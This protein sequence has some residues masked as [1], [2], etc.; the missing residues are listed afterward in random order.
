[1]RISGIFLVLHRGRRQA[2]HLMLFKKKQLLGIMNCDED[3]ASTPSS[4]FRQ[5]SM[6]S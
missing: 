4:V 3:H 6:M 5:S 2:N 1:M